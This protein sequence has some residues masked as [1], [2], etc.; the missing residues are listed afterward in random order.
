MV[1]LFHNIIL[2][3]QFFQ[4]DDVALIDLL[5]VEVVGLVEGDDQLQEFGHIAVLQVLPS[6]EDII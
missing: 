5:V 6:L 2:F 3:N 4:V 1:S